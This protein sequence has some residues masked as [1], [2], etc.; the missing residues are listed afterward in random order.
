MR[1]KSKGSEP[2]ASG[3]TLTEAEGRVGR[4]GPASPGLPG[5]CPQ[6]QRGYTEGGTSRGKFAERKKKIR[7]W[8]NSPRKPRLAAIGAQRKL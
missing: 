2:E 8:R 7:M 5:A 6:S 1:A 3:D 4:G